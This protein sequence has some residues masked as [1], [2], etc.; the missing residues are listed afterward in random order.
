MRCRLKH[1]REETDSADLRLSSLASKVST[2]DMHVVSLDQVLAH[3]HALW[4]R[5]DAM[6]TD[7]AGV[8]TLVYEQLCEYQTVKENTINFSAWTRGVA[9][10]T[11]PMRLL[12]SDSRAALRRT[13]MQIVGR[14]LERD[15]GDVKAICEKLRRINIAPA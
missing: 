2:M 14:L 13:T 1:L 9:D 6:E 3:T 4:A 7:S 11:A 5:V 15:Q 12:G 8:K 10:E